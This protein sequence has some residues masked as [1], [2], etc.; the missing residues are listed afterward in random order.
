MTSDRVK[1]EDGGATAQVNVA[2]MLAGTYRVTA[3]K[4]VSVSGFKGTIKKGDE[5][6]LNGDAARALMNE[7]SVERA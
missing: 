5:V 7:G 4:G 2:D 6:E 3:E 1:G